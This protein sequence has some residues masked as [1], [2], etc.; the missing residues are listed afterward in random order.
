MKTIDKKTPYKWRPFDEARAFVHSLG[1]NNI[2]EWNQWRKTDA[3]SNDIPS[4][5]D[6]VYKVKGW[7]SWGDWLGT[8]RIAN[9][10]MIYRSFEKARAFARNLKLKNQ[11]EPVSW[12]R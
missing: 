5:P 9:S 1:L 11:K 6:R 7:I 2:A 10:Q 8:G 12:V 4:S 3:R